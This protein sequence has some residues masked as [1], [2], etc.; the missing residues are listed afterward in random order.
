MKT[1][2]IL[3][4]D[5]HPGVFWQLRTSISEASLTYVFR[6]DILR[7][8]ELQCL[9]NSCS[10]LPNHMTSQ[11]NDYNLQPIVIADLHAVISSRCQGMVRLDPALSVALVSAD[12]P[13]IS[14]QVTEV[15]LP[16]TAPTEPPSSHQR[17][18]PQE[19]MVHLQLRVPQLVSIRDSF[20]AKQQ[21]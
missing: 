19:G 7:R 8:W 16:L 1:A 5:F 14:T 18:V 11:S 3:R 6:A 17:G 10:Y 13:L 2:V 4:C 20:H 15:P 12:I 21:R 9:K